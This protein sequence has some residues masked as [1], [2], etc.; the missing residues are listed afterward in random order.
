MAGNSWQ[1]PVA[2]EPSWGSPHTHVET[3]VDS[4]D[5]A[6]TGNV[7]VTCSNVPTGATG[8]FGFCSVLSATTAGRAL[9]IKDSS[10]N[11]FAGSRNPT[12]AIR[13]YTSFQVPLN[14]SKQFLYS[15]DNAD[16]N[17]VDIFMGGYFL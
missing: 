11:I 15:V 13:G 4:A 7:T 8:I 2:G 6:S 5:P 1:Q 16:V 14:S 10:G 17:D 9:F 3:L 12:T